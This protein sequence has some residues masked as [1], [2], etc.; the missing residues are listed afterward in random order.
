MARELLPSVSRAHE[1]AAKAVYGDLPRLSRKLVITL[2]QGS[3]SD[4]RPA[5]ASRLLLDRPAAAAAGAAVD[6]SSGGTW[7]RTMT[8]LRVLCDAVNGGGNGAP[9]RAADVALQQKVLGAPPRITMGSEKMTLQGLLEHFATERREMEQSI[10][11]GVLRAITQNV[12]FPAVAALV[13]NLAPP[14]A[15]KG[16][17]RQPV[18]LMD[19]RRPDSWVVEL[20]LDSPPIDMPAAAVTAREQAGIGGGPAGAPHRFAAGDRVERWGGPATD[21]WL[22]GTVTAARG[23]KEGVYHVSYDRG[24]SEKG[25]HRSVLRKAVDAG[26]ANGNG[27]NGANGG[28]GGGPGGGGEAG[29][30]AA[31]R[32][33]ERE[34]RVVHRR[35]CRAPLAPTDPGY[36]ACRWELVIVLDPGRGGAVVGCGLRI[37][38]LEC[39]PAMKRARR[40]SL[41]KFMTPEPAIVYGVA[42]EVARRASRAKPILT[43]STAALACV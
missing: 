37:I 22:P 36:F 11:F 13:T 1:T 16:A 14:P 26:S 32:H 20:Q 35:W 41:E 24:D 19:G 12:I 8:V 39:S 30:A 42:E 18:P 38:E 10:V 21:S 25:V 31:P 40:R 4:G 29:R 6:P 5:A 7:A 28:G 15:K 3:H 33:R 23:G 2:A 34:H 17:P 27:A 43:Y 9:R